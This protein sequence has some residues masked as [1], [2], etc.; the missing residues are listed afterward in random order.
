[1]SLNQD[2]GVTAYRVEAINEQRRSY[3]VILP[4]QR[5]SVDWKQIAWTFEKSNCLVLYHISYTLLYFWFH[6]CLINIFL[7][8]P[9][10]R[11]NLSCFL[12][13]LSKINETFSSRKSL[14]VK[15]CFVFQIFK[16]IFCKFY[17]SY[18]NTL[19]ESEVYLV[20]VG[21]LKFNWFSL[22]VESKLFRRSLKD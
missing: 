11:Q 12:E 13:L 6:N 14:S 10:T 22:I 8:L 17:A 20:T 2:I 18:Y 9:R 1:M 21:K 3:C 5:V 15:N 19:L 4:L 7:N 16:E